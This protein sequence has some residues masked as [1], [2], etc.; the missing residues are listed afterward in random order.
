MATISPSS[1]TPTVRS[2]LG[3]ALPHRDVVGMGDLVEGEVAGRLEG[4]LVRGG[5]ALGLRLVGHVPKAYAAAMAIGIITGSGTYAL[6]GFEGSGPRSVATAV[7]AALVSEGRFAGADVLHVS[8][9]GEG[10]V[11]LSSQVTHRANLAAL[12]E[13]G[14]TAVLA[15]TVAARSTPPSSW[16][17]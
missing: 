15:A 17:R 1:R 16:A 11:R 7:G 6:P 4:V 10:H 13:L 12:N 9:H 8:R 5:E 14:A 2:G 3:D